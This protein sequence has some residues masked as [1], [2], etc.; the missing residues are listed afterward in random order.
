M[1][2][3]TKFFISNLLLSDSSILQFSVKRQAQLINV[4]L[5]CVLG[6]KKD[7]NYESFLDNYENK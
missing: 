1:V 5:N 2:Q 7:G 6:T 4:N 3:Q